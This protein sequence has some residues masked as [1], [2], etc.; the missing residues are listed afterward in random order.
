[1]RMSQCK[2]LSCWKV[3]KSQYAGNMW[4]RKSMWAGQA[5]IWAELQNVISFTQSKSFKL[6]FTS[7]KVRK[8]RQI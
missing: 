7:R 3:D 2:Y 1:M 8:S 6:N 5:G 4:V